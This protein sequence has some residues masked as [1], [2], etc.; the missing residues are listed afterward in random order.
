MQELNNIGHA[1]GNQVSFS[2]LE[3]NHIL[4][5]GD[6]TYKFFT[7]KDQI[8]SLSNKAL[9]KKETSNLSTNYTA[10]VWLQDRILVGTNLGQIILCDHL[11]EYKKTLQ[12]STTET[13]GFCIEK[14][15]V[16]SKGF[17]IAGDRGQMQ[18]FFNTGEPNNPYM[19]IASL[20]NI[21][22]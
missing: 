3:Q 8:L 10:H 13:G 5:T 16:Y 14:F 21:N 2:N 6:N 20:P 1:F 11:G 9:N 17:I 22:I 7:M 4:V 19:K 15:L 18:V 12:D